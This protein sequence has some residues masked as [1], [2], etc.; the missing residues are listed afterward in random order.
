M[1]K[2]TKDLKN[3]WI[4][5][6]IN[7]IET[8]FIVDDETKKIVWSMNGLE[9]QY[10]YEAFFGREDICQF[11]PKLKKNE[12]Y[13]CECYDEKNNH[14]LKSK[15]N[16]FIDEGKILR[17][18]NF[19]MIDDA[20]NLSFDSVKE[21]SLLQK[22]LDENQRISNALEYE[23]T[24]DKMTGLLNRNC[25]NQDIA[26]GKYNVENLGVLYFD[27]NNLK[28]VNDT[29]RH[30]AGDRLICCLANSIKQLSDEVEESNGYRI[31]GDEFV[32]MISKCSENNI[33]EILDKFNEIIR[34]Y[35]K[36]D[37]PCVVAVGSA[38]SK[39]LCDAEQLVSEADKKMYICKKE[40]KKK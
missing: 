36:D 26:S 28:Y 14:W 24:H 34:K 2:K 39:D 13:T 40:M 38:F 8:A 31:G 23:A 33:K 4:K 32:L 37:P 16:L 17:A 12:F 19:N 22:L 30:E 18:E 3:K 5:P 15:S 11:C 25:Y 21:M 1:R 27:L 29:Y 7:C 9:G 35:E 10:C 20:M 6:L